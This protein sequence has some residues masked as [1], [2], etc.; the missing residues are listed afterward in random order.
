MTKVQYEYP[1]YIIDTCKY[2]NTSVITPIL[3]KSVKMA[4]RVVES[5]YTLSMF[6]K[7]RL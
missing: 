1:V 5:R 4:L 3:F 2:F 6:Y 7:E